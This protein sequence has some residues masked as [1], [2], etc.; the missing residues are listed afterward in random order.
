VNEAML[1]DIRAGDF[2]TIDI[3]RWKGRAAIV[4]SVHLKTNSLLVQP[5]KPSGDCITTAFVRFV[6]R[7]GAADVSLYAIGGESRELSRE[8]FPQLFEWVV[9]QAPVTEPFELP[10]LRGTFPREIDK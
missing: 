5:T 2:V 7:L 3:G 6:V 10:D 9:N 4:K 8:A 1:K